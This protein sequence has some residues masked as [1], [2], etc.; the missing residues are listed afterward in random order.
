MTNSK[1]TETHVLH[2][3]TGQQVSFSSVLLAT[4]QVIVVTHIGESINAR[5]LIDQGS[6]ISLISERL[7]KVLRLPRNQSV[8]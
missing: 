6:E 1:P 3:S 4:A 7:V 2:S 5:A 8:I